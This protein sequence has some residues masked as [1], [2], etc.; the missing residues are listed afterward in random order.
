MD[1]FSD[2]TKK[3]K[4]ISKE[5]MKFSQSCGFYKEN[6]KEPLKKYEISLNSQIY[7]EN[8]KGCIKKVW[9]LAKFSYSGKE[10]ERNP[11]R[12]LKFG[13]TSRFTTKIQRNP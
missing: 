1:Q 2:L 5:N 10:I 8:T 11:Y 6:T 9:D 13:W 4:G 7:K 3:H 12:S